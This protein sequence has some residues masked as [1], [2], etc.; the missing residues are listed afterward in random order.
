MSKEIHA[1]VP[2]MQHK[3]RTYRQSCDPPP[4]HRVWIYLESGSPFLGDAL[5]SCMRK[6][7]PCKNQWF[8]DGTIK[9]Q[10]IDIA[11]NLLIYW[12]L[13]VL[14]GAS[15]SIRVNCIKLAEIGSPNRIHELRS[16]R[17]VYLQ[18]IQCQ[19]RNAAWRRCKWAIAEWIRCARFGEGASKSKITVQLLDRR[20]PKCCKGLQ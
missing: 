3:V 6:T 13:H 17:W 14:N 1:K 15:N 5:A 19:W 7:F 10:N 11:K 4:L 16:C 20:F 8:I 2:G 18:M 12:M 9:G